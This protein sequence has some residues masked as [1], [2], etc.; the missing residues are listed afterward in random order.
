MEL[1]SVNK[2][3]KRHAAQLQVAFYVIGYAV[4]SSLLAIINKV[5]SQ[6]HLSKFRTVGVPKA[7]QFRARSR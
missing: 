6:W 5:L 1:S 4:S 7:W 3:L 2:N